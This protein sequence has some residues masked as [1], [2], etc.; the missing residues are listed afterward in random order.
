MW[1]FCPN[2]LFKVGSL[3]RCLEIETV[4][5]CINVKFNWQGLCPPKVEV[6]VWQL[7]MGQIP[8]MKVLKRFGYVQNFCTDCPL[9]NECEESIDHHFLSCPW[10]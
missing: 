1:K 7:Q 5:D 10:S 4:K 8:V 6:F 9:C 3:R 2:G